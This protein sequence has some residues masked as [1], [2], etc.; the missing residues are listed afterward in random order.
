M[1]D[2]RLMTVADMAEACAYIATRFHA[3]VDYSCPIWRIM[4]PSGRI[5]EGFSLAEAVTW[6]ELR[7]P[8]HVPDTCSYCQQEFTFDRPWTLDAGSF[9]HA[10]CL[11]SAWAEWNQCRIEHE[12]ELW[13]QR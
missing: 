7:E 13:S 5:H 2:L 10:N 1:T 11:R 6:Y 9:F 4:A 8:E 3:T 12:A